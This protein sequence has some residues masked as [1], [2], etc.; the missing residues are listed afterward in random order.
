MVLDHVDTAIAMAGFILKN[1][2][3]ENGGVTRGVCKIE[4]GHSYLTDVEETSNIVRWKWEQ[5]QME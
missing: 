1:T 5:R 4:D 3:S 2:S